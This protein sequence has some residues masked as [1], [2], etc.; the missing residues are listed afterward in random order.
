MQSLFIFAI[1]YTAILFCNII[2][3]IG[4]NLSPNIN[5]INPTITKLKIIGA[6]AE[7]KIINFN[8]RFKKILSS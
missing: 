2:D 7:N 4:G 5:N 6:E 1:I 8:R 3:I